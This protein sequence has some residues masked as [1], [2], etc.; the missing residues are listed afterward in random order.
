MK[1]YISA[2]I[3]GITGLVAWSQCGGPDDDDTHDFDFAR[4]MMTSDVNAAIRGARKAG[5]TQVV[6]KDSHGGSLNL[7]VEELEPGTELISGTGAGN[8][9]MMSGIDS[10]F[11]CAMLVG[12]HAMAGTIGGILAH[13]MTGRLH[14]FFVNGVPTGE[15]GI[16]AATAGQ[17]G[18]PL[19]MVASD[20]SGCR[21][22]EALI[23]G[24]KT[25]TVKE[26]I[27]RQMGKVLHPEVT[28]AFIEKAAKAGVEAR[29]SIAP[30]KVALPVTIKLE[31]NRGEDGDRDAQLPGWTQ[32][33]HYTF[34]YT[35]DSWEEAHRA[36][37]A[38]F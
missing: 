33:D 20:L 8:D 11:D 4:R 16:S 36:A 30:F 7:L 24:I 21:E 27:G 19:V 18:V 25:A 38:A 32:I 23:P 9:G 15:M 14:R 12:Y 5:A 29:K 22:I 28:S 6:V 34:E 2:D 37:W 35:A 3:E 17:Y 10:S 31:Q 1:V 26:G 13:T